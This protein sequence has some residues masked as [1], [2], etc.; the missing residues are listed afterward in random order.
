MELNDIIADLNGFLG[1]EAKLD[2]KKTEAPKKEPKVE[3]RTDETARELIGA[4]LGSVEENVKVD[5]L[6]QKLF[7][8][9]LVVTEEVGDPHKLY[10]AVIE[11]FFGAVADHGRKI[12]KTIEEACCDDAE[13]PAEETEEND[14]EST[15]VPEEREV[16]DAYKDVD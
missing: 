10:K 4:V 2:A 5:V 7:E 3:D 11:D 8:S 14:E 12:L 15:E 1:E 6:A 16:A 13:D 9:T